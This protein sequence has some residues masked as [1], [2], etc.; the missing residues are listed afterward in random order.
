[1][2]GVLVFAAEAGEEKSHAV[3]Y[4]VGISLACWAVAV[5]ALGILRPERFGERAGARNGVLAVTAL[6]VAGTCASAVLSSS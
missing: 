3:F 2:H 5:A 1:M 6:L 4:F